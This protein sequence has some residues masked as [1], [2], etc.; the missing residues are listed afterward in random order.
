LGMAI[1]MTVPLREWLVSPLLFRGLVS[2]RLR[3]ERLLVSM[4]SLA[5]DV[6]FRD[7]LAER[8]YK[9]TAASSGVDAFLAKLLDFAQSL[10]RSEVSEAQLPLRVVSPGV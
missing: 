8:D 6:T 1:L 2:R 5:F 3:P 10:S 4:P 7:V 9:A